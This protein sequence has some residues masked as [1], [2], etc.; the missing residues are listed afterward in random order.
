MPQTVNVTASQNVSIPSDVYSMK[1]TLWGA[2]GGGEHV[3]VNTGIATGGS[4][5]GDTKFMGLIARGGNGGTGKVGGSGGGIQDELGWGSTYSVSVSGT[6]GNSGA[7]NAGG[8]GYDNK[9]SGGNGS[10]KVVSFTSSV[11]HIFDNNSN[12][13]TYTNSSNDITTTYEN[14]G[15]ADGLSC[16]TDSSGKRYGIYFNVPYDN[17]NYTITMNSF[18]QQAAGGSTTGP[19]SYAGFSDKNQFGFK[20]YFCR[21]GK[22]S[23]IRCFTLTTYG[24]KSSLLAAGGGAGG[25]LV[26]SYIPRDTLIQAGYSP[27]SAPL[28]TIGSGGTRG[29]VRAANGNSGYASIEFII[30]AKI[31]LFADGN[32]TETFIVVGDTANLTWNV[33]GDADTTYLD[34]VEVPNNGGPVVV[35]PTVS[36]TYTATTSGLGGSDT[37]TVLVRVYQKPTLQLVFS[38]ATQYGSKATLEYE[39]EY[40]NISVTITPQYKYRNANNDGFDTVNGTAVSLPASSLPTSAEYD[41]PGSLVSGS[42]ELDIPYNDDGPFEV[43]YTVEAKG[44][45]GT[46]TKSATTKINIDLSPDNIVI[47]EATGQPNEEPVYSP[48][49]V[50]FPDTELV[51][52]DIDIP[53]EIKADKPIKISLDNG[54]TWL[55]IREKI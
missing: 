32:A 22:N 31:N 19:F 40:A 39:I 3:Q 16:S 45:G 48:D 42:I 4:K 47:P 37:D 23:Y 28:A 49:P 38:Q 36:T 35:S 27:G 12:T 51:V 52:A 30:Q 34:G 11:E 24:E 14:A 15:A 7:V 6:T 29:G 18:C 41:T 8:S 53:V 1:I 5:G 17:G 55:N 46:E 54:N 33:S 21:V 43:L 25:K 9:G 26:T 44:D 20:V 13:H 2:G 10:D 50:D